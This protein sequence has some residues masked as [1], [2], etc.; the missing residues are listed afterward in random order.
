MHY[1]ST[2]YIFQRSTTVHHFCT[3]SATNVLQ[4]SSVASYVM[5]TESTHVLFSGIMHVS[6]SVVSICT[7]TRDK[8]YA[9][10]AGQ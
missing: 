1:F 10:T 6:Y 7:N 4:D 3:E 8:E 5:F 2:L 9:R